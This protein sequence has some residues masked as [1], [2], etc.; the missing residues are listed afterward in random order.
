MIRKTAIGI[1]IFAIMTGM[2]FVQIGYGWWGVNATVYKTPWMIY[3]DDSH[4]MNILIETDLG[5][6]DDHKHIYID[7][8][9]DSACDGDH[10]SD[11]GF[12]Y[13]KMVKDNSADTRLWTF[14]CTGLTPVTDY[15]FKVCVRDWDDTPWD[16][17]SGSFQTAPDGVTSHLG[18][19]AYGDTRGESK[20]NDVS[21]AIKKDYDNRKGA[22]V[23]HTGDVVFR[24]G[25]ECHWDNQQVVCPWDEFW[26]YDGVSTM[27][28]HIPMFT[29][30]GNHDFEPD[31]GDPDNAHFYYQ[32]F[33][34]P[35]YG[36][37][38]SGSS[39]LGNF[40]YSFGW[41]PADFFSLTTYP[42]SGY[43]DYSY[44]V[45]EG[46]AQYNW[47]A[48]SLEKLQGDGRW[49]I[50]F[51]HGP[52]YD[53][54]GSTGCSQEQVRQYLQPL[55]EKYGV[56]L[57]L[58][59]HE[60]YY[61]RKFVPPASDPHTL[62]HMVLGGGGATLEG[63]NSPNDV[64]VS[65]LKYHYAYFHIQGDQMTIEA[66]DLGGNKI[67][68]IVLDKSPKAD[69]GVWNTQVGV[70]PVNVYFKNLSTGHASSYLWDFGDGGTSTEKEPTHSYTKLGTYTVS[71]TTSSPFNTNTNTKTDF[72]LVSTMDA[73]FTADKT[74]GPVGLV[75][76][77]TPSCWDC[78]YNYWD[79]GFG[80]STAPPG[81]IYAYYG[82]NGIFDVIHTVGNDS[83]DRVTV[84]K[85]GY[86]KI[87]PY[88][89][90]SAV[91]N[92][93]TVQ[94]DN[95]SG[96]ENLT[97]LWDFGDGSGS[98]KPS[99]SHTYSSVGTF[100][101]KLT[102]T[103]DKGITHSS[104]LDV[105][106]SFNAGF[107]A[108]PTEGPAPLVVQVTPSSS[109]DYPIDTWDMGDGNI[110]NNQPGGPF[111]HTYAKNGKFAVTHTVGDSAGST[112]TISKYEYIKVAPY[113]EFDYAVR[114]ICGYSP[115][116]CIPGLS[117]DCTWKCTFLVSFTNKSD[118]SN[119]TYHWDFGD[120]TSSTDPSPDHIYDEL[121]E[122]VV[123]TVSNGTAIDSM[124]KY[125]DSTEGLP[126][127][128]GSWACLVKARLGLPCR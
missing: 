102:V 122:K 42:M 66:I 124:T 36:D 120:G 54:G 105:K 114:P 12:S 68:T 125:I 69:F 20:T 96:G 26:D 11:C 128:D 88:A 15:S 117:R 56:D 19:Y 108:A 49:K 28:A 90:F 87:Q 82:K 78:Q 113:A 99:P 80:G 17:Y 103:D 51:F 48:D 52:P 59:G 5:V 50:V 34:Y 89:E 18:F 58:A 46:T 118:G 9:P 7:L 72:V 84:K 57:V 2:A 73:E 60:H 40:Y 22:F 112:T 127:P 93:M 85:E 39:D 119:L 55:F 70:P 44:P 106:A 27:L 86:I 100:T 92:E 38:P 4:K 77:F 33:K 47:F 98:T 62:L 67:D 110:Y 10:G 13:Y 3:P 111:T 31:S 95:K 123:L 104:T 91:T 79:I 30:I 126:L 14:E 115:S 32:Y 107:T 101:V 25:H 21:S 74:E 94:F 43:C 24:G 23:I 97:Y 76:D 109:S 41:G 121:G 65:A 63:L 35:M 6:D 71:L 75:V 116:G 29:T 83:G 16:S 37:R 61:A 64:D 45:V 81:D 1:S 53:A 8:N